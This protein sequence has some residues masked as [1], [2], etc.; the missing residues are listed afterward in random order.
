MRRLTFWRSHPSRLARV[1][2]ISLALVAMAVPANA[3]SWAEVSFDGTLPKSRGVLANFRDAVGAYR[4][5]FRRNVEK[6]VPMVS[7]IIKNDFVVTSATGNPGEIRVNSYDRATGISI[8][9]RFYIA[10]VC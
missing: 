1:A 5:V 2:I 7:S 4:I 9:T 8:D 10:L 3:G 6:C